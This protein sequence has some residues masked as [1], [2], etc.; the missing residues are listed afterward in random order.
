MSEEAKAVQELAK[1]ASNY[2]KSIDKLGRF[3]AGVIGPVMNETSG[4]LADAIRYRRMTNA[5]NYQ[6]RI[7][8]LIEQRGVTSIRPLPLATAYPL[9]DAASLEEDATLAEMFANLFVSYVDADR[10]GYLPKLFTETISKLS[11]YEVRILTAIHKAPASALDE[12][13]A[14]YTL[15]LPDGYMPAPVPGD[16][17]HDEPKGDLQIALRNLERLGCIDGTWVWS[18]ISMRQV[19]INEYGRAFLSACSGG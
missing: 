16:Q 12:S 6:V 4:L 15:Q 9:L 17:M 10:E 2:Q 19:K 18:F 7:E 11:P 13:E 14:M 3:I 1:T 5:I 8:A